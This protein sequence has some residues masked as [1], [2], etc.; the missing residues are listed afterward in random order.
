MLSSCPKLTIYNSPVRDCAVSG[1][2]WKK[3]CQQAKAAVLC[4]ERLDLRSG[5]LEP[6]GTLSLPIAAVL[7]GPSEASSELP[8]MPTGTHNSLGM[9]PKKGHLM[10]LEGWLE[11]MLQRMH[12]LDL[13]ANQDHKSMQKVFQFRLTVSTGLVRV[14]TRCCVHYRTYVL[15]GRVTRAPGGFYFGW[16]VHQYI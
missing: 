2:E 9:N 3:M 12:C 5:T 6:W 4:P 11:G 1:H 8:G 7:V 16:R 10:R 15:I 14:K 13:V